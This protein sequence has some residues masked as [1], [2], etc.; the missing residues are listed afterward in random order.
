M[1]AAGGI[2]GP[3]SIGDAYVGRRRDGKLQRRD[4]VKRHMPVA[5]LARDD[6]FVRIAM[7]D[8]LT[9]PRQAT[10]EE[11][12]PGGAEKRGPAIRIHHP[13]A[14]D[15]ARSLM[16]GIFVG[17]VQALEGAGRTCWDFESG[18]GQ[19]TPDDPDAASRR[20]PSSSSSTWPASAGT[21]PA[22]SRS[23]AS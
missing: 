20:C 19:S 11:E 1:F 10:K 8:R 4:L 5:D 15:A 14:P 7:Q 12:R 3:G 18:S 2:A 23:P 17:E 16:H 13:N 6:R 21:R 22:T 9:D